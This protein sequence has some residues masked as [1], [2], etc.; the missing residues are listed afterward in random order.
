VVVK[1]LAPGEDRGL[2]ACNHE[3]H[4]ILSASIRIFDSVCQVLTNR[5]V[6]SG[7][8]MDASTKACVDSVFKIIGMENHVEDL[9]A[10]EALQAMWQNRR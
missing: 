2:P 8:R 10:R 3:V 6:A 4:R 1:E 9:S 5:P 7:C